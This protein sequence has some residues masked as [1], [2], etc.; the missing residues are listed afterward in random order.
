MTPRLTPERPETGGD[1]DPIA[2]LKAGLDA[3][4][5]FATVARL[6]QKHRDQML[7]E[8]AAHREILDKYEATEAY[9]RDRQYAEGTWAIF[10]ARDAWKQAALALASIYVSP[11]GS[12]STT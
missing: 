8:V 4:E 6:P 10:I 2:R 7:R 3:D 11:G 1:A 12:R 9:C 5:H